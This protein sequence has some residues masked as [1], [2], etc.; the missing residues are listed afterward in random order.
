MWFIPY[1]YSTSSE[2][3]DLENLI[4]KH[5]SIFDYSRQR[6]HQVLEA[7]YFFELKK[8]LTGIAPITNT[9]AKQQQ[10]NKT[11][12]LSPP[13]Q[14]SLPASPLLSLRAQ[15]S[16]PLSPPEAI[17]STKSVT[18]AVFRQS[19]P[20]ETYFV[21]TQS[22]E[23]SKLKPNKHPMPLSKAKAVN[24]Q[25][26][27][28][29]WSLSIEERIVATPKDGSCLIAALAIADGYIFNDLFIFPYYPLI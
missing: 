6:A 16:L 29:K 3:L 17:S 12:P 19:K 25:R 15:S 10:T 14:S 21:S 28:S 18:P 11:L 20:I 24:K 8:A 26:S 22:K 5:W 7:T 1:V 2:F 4:R 27:Q 13:L 23:P 9:F